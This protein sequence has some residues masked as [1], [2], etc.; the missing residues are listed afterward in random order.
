M[1][2]LHR[3]Q[4]YIHETDMAELRL[5]AHREHVTVSEIVRKAIHRFLRIERDDITWEH[6]PL[7]KTVGQIELTV[8][9]ASEKHDEYLY[10]PKQQDE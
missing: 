4:L 9:D 1:A 2:E 3:T 10:G 5:E 8:R 7:V 6:D